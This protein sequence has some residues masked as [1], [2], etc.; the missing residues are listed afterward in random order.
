MVLL[1]VFCCCC[2]FCTVFV[3][4]YQFRRMSRYSMSTF[5]PILLHYSFVIQL[6]ILAFIYLATCQNIVISMNKQL[7]NNNRMY[8]YLQ[9]TK[10][11]NVCAC[12]RVCVCVCACVCV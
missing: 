1:F 2:C 4:I 3:K 8:F 11:V 12:M 6:S 9:T 7:L 10:C 5:C